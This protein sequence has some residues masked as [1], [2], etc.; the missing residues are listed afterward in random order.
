MQPGTYIH[1][2][3][4]GA[5]GR[6]GLAGLWRRLRAR[7][8]R[9][10]GDEVLM[11]RARAGDA[12]AFDALVSRHRTRLHALGLD[13]LE[14]E[15]LS[16][17]VLSDTVL[18]AFRNLDSL[19]EPCAPGTWLYLHGLRAVFRRVQAPERE[20]RGEGRARTS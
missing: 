13:S 20:P 2:R 12:T 6:R 10:F 8:F 7:A 3:S 4:L 15:G 5:S 11:R 9:I 14:R 19:G 16:G 1:V 17:D 18:T